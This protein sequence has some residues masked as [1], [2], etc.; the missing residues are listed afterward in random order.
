[1]AVLWIGFLLVIADCVA[2]KLFDDKIRP[3]L[4]A[5]AAVNAVMLIGLICIVIGIILLVVG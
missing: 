5:K 4:Y 2:V 3:H 1:M